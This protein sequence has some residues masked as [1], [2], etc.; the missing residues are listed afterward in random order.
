M[1]PTTTMEPSP[2][3]PLTDIELR[4]EL[5][6]WSEDLFLQAAEA[7][8]CP[9]MDVAKFAILGQLGRGFFGVVYLARKSSDYFAIKV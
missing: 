6:A 9:S 2:V 1:L 4:L 8:E 7:D 3:L 5:N